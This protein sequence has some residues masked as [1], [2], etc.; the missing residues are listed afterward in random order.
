MILKVLCKILKE[1]F[2]FGNFFSQVILASVLHCNVYFYITQV[3]SNGT[4]F[5]TNWKE[6]GS[7]KVKEPS[8]MVWR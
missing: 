5:S 4:V 6:V 8:M 1:I 7:K 2:L 3:E